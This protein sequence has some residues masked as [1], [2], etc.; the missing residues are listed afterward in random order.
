MNIY[1]DMGIDDKVYKLSES[2]LE[3]LSD[4]FNE[5]DR[6]AEINQLKVVKAM[7]ESKVSEACLLGT[8]GYGYNDI[9]RDTLE[10]VYS[11]IFHTEAALVRPQ[12][13]C[14]THALALAL[15]SNLRPGDELLSPVGKP[16]DTLEEVIGIR[17]SMGSLAEYGIT[18]S[19]VDLL[20]NGDY[21]YEGIR[22]AINDKTKLVTIQRSKGYQTRRSLSVESIGELISFIKS[23]RRQHF[24]MI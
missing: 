17:P 5:I 23:I 3:G 19:Q 11:R 14:G 4:R 1:K 10:E 8:T 21:D 9:G 7:Q 12:I 13:T 20:S 16:Y 2:I 6:V 22:K 18:Y 15:M 24:F